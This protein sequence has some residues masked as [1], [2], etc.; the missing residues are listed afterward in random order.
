M[1]RGKNEGEVG[2]RNEGGEGL[3]KEGRGGVMEG[4]RRGYNKGRRRGY[5]EGRKGG[6][7]YRGE[8]KGRGLGKRYIDRVFSPWYTAIQSLFSR[9]AAGGGR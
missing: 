9:G 7:V 1:R 3:R 8:F 2:I 5:N 6:G 4:R